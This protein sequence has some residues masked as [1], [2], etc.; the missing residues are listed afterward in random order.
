MQ[1][2]HILQLVIVLIR[3]HII[4]TIIDPTQAIDIR[5]WR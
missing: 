3:K 5:C 2:L 4:L 1:S